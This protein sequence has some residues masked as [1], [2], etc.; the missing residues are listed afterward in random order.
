VLKAD[1][2]VKIQDRSTLTYQADRECSNEYLAQK[3]TVADDQS[4]DQSQFS[5]RHGEEE[6]SLLNAPYI[7]LGRG[8]SGTRLLSILAED[9]GIFIGNDVNKSGDSSEM[10]GPI[11]RSVVRKHRAPSTWQRTQTVPDLRRAA[12]AMLDRWGGNSSWGFKLPETLLVLPEISA[13]FPDARFVF[14]SRDPAATVLRRTHMTARLDNHIG[15]IALA[16]AYDYF[17]IPRIQMLTDD[18]LTRMA[19]TT[20]HHRA[21]ADTHRS[22]VGEENWLQLQY[23]ATMHDPISE[24]T[25]FA[26]FSGRAVTHTSIAEVVDI[27]R[28]TTAAA[29]YSREQT[30]AV[31]ALIADLSRR[32]PTV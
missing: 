18:G 1:E 7:L 4:V 11:Y 15:R 16:A 26:E 2:S 31:V 14:F 9:L 17:E 27:P 13:A 12:A 29:Q 30:D 6:N 19:I 20:V 22:T 32:P 8:G 3:W 28:S 5:E 21:L 25:R 23:E 24:L 10:I